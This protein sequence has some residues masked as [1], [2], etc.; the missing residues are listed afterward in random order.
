[1]LRNYFVLMAVAASV[2]LGG[3]IAPTAI[4]TK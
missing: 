1:M 2:T 4:N 3:M